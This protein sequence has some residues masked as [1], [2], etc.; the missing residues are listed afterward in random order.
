MQASR[1]KLFVWYCIIVKWL[2]SFLIG[3]GEWKFH[4]FVKIALLILVAYCDV[5]NE[6]NVISMWIRVVH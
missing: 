2:F 1:G 5:T 6:D 3:I 4:F